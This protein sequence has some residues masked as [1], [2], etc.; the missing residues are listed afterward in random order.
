MY[1][2]CI[3]PVMFHTSLNIGHISLFVDWFCSFQLTAS[4]FKSPWP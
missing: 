3:E 1:A 4:L 2:L